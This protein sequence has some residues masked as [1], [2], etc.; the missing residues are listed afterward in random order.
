[1]NANFMQLDR[2]PSAGE[3]LQAHGVFQE[4]GGK[5][6]NLGVGLH[7]L[8][9]KVRLLLGIGADNAGKSAREF[10]T[11]EGLD[12]RG[13][14]D[15]PANSG[16][17]VG[18][19][20]TNGKNFLAAYHGANTLI[21]EQHVQA[22]CQ[23]MN[24]L[25][26]VCA[27]FEAPDNAILAAF[28]I[29][30]QRGAM[31]YLNPSPWRTPSAQMLALTDVL[32]VNATEAALMFALPAAEHWD[33]QTW[34]T[35]LPTLP[36]PYA[37]LIVTLAEHGAISISASGEIHHQA[38]FNITQIDATGA[39]DAFGCGLV[40]ALSQQCDIAHTLHLANACGARVA[41]SKGILDALPYPTQITEFIATQSN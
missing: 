32:V 36:H 16:Y 30:K 35:Q 41:A 34:L 14:Y 19:I 11:S 4:H 22:Q 9:L 13:V 27:Q 18:F 5:G 7:R 3:S 6:L 21:N 10:L 31:T 15:L 2:L 40:Y 17:G 29:G 24:Q 25:D 39:G 23:S 8:G 33:A 26:W 20:A 37:Y 1:M 38:A 28:E 12:M